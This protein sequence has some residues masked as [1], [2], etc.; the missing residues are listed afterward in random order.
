MNQVIFDCDCTAGIPG[1]PMDDALAL[2][3]LLGR[4]EAAKILGVCCTF[5]NSSADAVFSATKQILLE[6]GQGN[7]PVFAGAN[8]EENPISDA[9]RFIVTQVNRAP[10][11]ISII[12]VGSLTNLYGAFLLD[13]HLFEKIKE[14]VLMGGYTEPLLYHG[15]HLDELNFSVAPKASAAVLTH[16]KNLSILTGNNTLLP[17]YLH[18]EEFFA[19]M[20][21]TKSGRMIAQKLGYRFDVKQQRNGEAAS[22]C[23]DVVAS[24]YLLHPELFEDHLCSCYITEKGMTSGW[25]GVTQSAPDTCLLNLPTVKDL[26]RYRQEMYAGWLHFPLR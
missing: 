10:G 11:E 23:W 1:Y 3:Y 22:Y 26:S 18:K 5:G 24:I 4:P 12:A 6:T 2:F 7:L 25:L 13:P 16:G 15:K 21:K 14:I 9:A 19:E 17:S 20:S 8:A